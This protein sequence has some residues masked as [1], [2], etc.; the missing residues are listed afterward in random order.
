MPL[1]PPPPVQR[2]VLHAVW[3]FQVTPEACTAQARAGNAGLQVTVRREGAI[4]LV[5]SLPG[6][7]PLKPV[8]RFAGPAGRWTV[9]GTSLG[10]GQSAF[11][12][13]RS[14]ST[15]SKLLILLSGGVVEADPDLESAPILAV[16]E[17]GDGGRQ[18][19]D[20]ARRSVT[21]P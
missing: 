15:L 9:G 3:A 11:L 13:P 12:L 7:P 6:V 14:D 10:H 8:A 1:P 16:P 21:G 2:R 18:W 17:S 20:C 19:F 4:R 5:V